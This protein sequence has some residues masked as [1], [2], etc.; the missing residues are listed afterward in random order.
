MP[1]SQE[2]PTKGILKTPTTQ[3][4]LS[5]WKRLQ[6]KIITSH[7]NQ[8]TVQPAAVV[9]EWSDILQS[10]SGGHLGPS[11][12]ETPM[13]GGHGSSN[14]TTRTENTPV[15]LTR[16]GSTSSM[17]STGGKLGFRKT[18]LANVSA[19]WRG[20][21]DSSKHHERGTS[22]TSKR[23]SWQ[24]SGHNLIRTSSSTGHLERN[25]S[26]RGERT[27]NQSLDLSQ[28]G[29][30]L[31]EAP[32]GTVGPT[33]E[34]PSRLSLQVDSLPPSR[35][36]EETLAQSFSEALWK[37]ELVNPSTDLNPSQL[38]RVR[39]SLPTT[40]IEYCTEDCIMSDSDSSISNDLNSTSPN[41]NETDR[42]STAEGQSHVSKVQVDTAK[43][44]EVNSSI[45]SPTTTATKDII[46]ERLNVTRPFSD[47][48][49]PSTT[50]PHLVT[51]SSNTDSLNTS[52]QDDPRFSAR[53]RPNVIT[54][55]S[56]SSS[57]SLRKR[58]SHRQPRD[59]RVQ[60]VYPLNLVLDAYRRACLALFELPLPA[61]ESLLVSHVSRKQPLTTLSLTGQVLTKPRIV[62]LA[63]MLDL[64]FGLRRLELVD[65]SIDDNGIKVLMHSLM[66]ADQ[67]EYLVLAGNKKIK[68]DGMAYLAT[69]VKESV[70]LKS[71]DLSGITFDRKMVRYLCSALVPRVWKNPL[72]FDIQPLIP[73]SLLN[74][75]PPN[76]TAPSYLRHCALKILRLD[77]CG[78]K[79]SHLEQLG[80][81]I[82]FSR[83]RH[84]SLRL[85]KISPLSVSQWA[86][87]LFKPRPFL[88]S[89]LQLKDGRSSGGAS[90]LDS[91]NEIS[92]S[93]DYTSS[94][95]RNTRKSGNLFPSSSGLLSLFTPLPGQGKSLIPWA[96]LSGQSGSLDGPSTS[97]ISLDL[98]DNELKDG[99]VEI[100]Q[101]LEQYTNTLESL[102]LCNNRLDSTILMEFATA[103]SHNRGLRSLDMSR[104]PMCGPT[105]QGTRSL[106][107]ALITNHYLKALYLENT[108]MTDES[109]IVIAERLSDVRHLAH[110]NLSQNEGVGLAG[111]MALAASVK[112]NQSLVCLE[113]SIAPNDDIMSKLAQD[114]LNVCVNNMQN[115]QSMESS[116]SVR[117]PSGQSTK[118]SLSPSSCQS[119]RKDISERS[120]EPDVSFDENSATSAKKSEESVSKTNPLTSP[121]KVSPSTTTDLSVGPSVPTGLASS[122]ESTPL[123][124]LAIPEQTPYDVEPMLTSPTVINTPSSVS[125]DS[126]T[127][128]I[129]Q[130]VDIKDLLDS[131]FRP[132]S[133]DCVSGDVPSTAPE[134]TS[135]QLIP[136]EEIAPTDC[137]TELVPGNLATPSKSGSKVHRFHPLLKT[138]VLSNS[139]APSTTPSVLAEHHRALRQ[140]E[141]IVMKKAKE[142]VGALITSPS[143]QSD[144]EQSA[145]DEEV[146]TYHM[147]VS[148]PPDEDVPESASILSSHSGTPLSSRNMDELSSG[149]SSSVSLLV[150][151]SSFDKQN[152]ASITTAAKPIA[153]VVNSTPS[154]MAPGGQS[155]GSLGTRA[156]RSMSSPIRPVHHSAHA[157]D[158]LI[159]ASRTTNTLGF[160]SRHISLLGGKD[161]TS[162]SSTFPPPPSSLTSADQDKKIVRTV[163]L[164]VRQSTNGNASTPRANSLSPPLIAGRGRSSSWQHYSGASNMRFPDALLVEYSGE[165][166]K[167]K[168]LEGGFALK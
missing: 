154:A 130:A 67:L 117:S 25:S 95:R 158:D 66:Y 133:P 93:Y 21:G 69:Y 55:Q 150:T 31:S 33:L 28:V 73:R 16:Q 14:G 153:E 121:P 1:R 105:L 161:V 61:V 8:A 71:L 53:A 128:I 155:L 32:P 102:S 101:L 11:P 81:A 2:S 116:D 9:A 44:S 78:L 30:P 109:A 45:T 94:G 163:V 139:P 151:E 106:A 119:S 149:L 39:F 3:P 74:S 140:E 59:P 152:L 127:E 112:M 131:S 138:P 48:L 6:S 83:I 125:S 5:V 4:S 135:S 57:T 137:R 22:K 34:T 70:R 65:C 24:V 40:V 147:L 100:G 107:E 132:S 165:E 46:S 115:Q 98:S 60:A 124:P 47:E 52:S 51:S 88:I 79:A 62:P 99:V 87:A 168:L 26:L 143:M 35:N 103:L 86:T 36:S 38:R 82:H 7:P 96:P 110:L 77:G 43:K 156:H 162:S 58:F 54:D 146:E 126:T 167:S 10:T 89:S 120:S 27:A 91:P 141:G 159:P 50:S 29:H 164:P 75:G 90:P 157:P 84:L 148:T 118:T 56:E 37:L 144:S 15:S 108:G 19:L 64:N 142:V 85:N 166:L 63:E 134:S 49:S 136:N 160:L 12:R 20:H 80:L 114:I 104:N 113:V 122:T 42:D 17:R 123:Q 41:S 129:S 145:S 72:P 13:Q 18:A 92:K 97:L 76:S 111:V 23:L 68:A